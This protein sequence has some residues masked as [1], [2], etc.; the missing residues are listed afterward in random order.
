MTKSHITVLL[1]NILDVNSFASFLFRSMFLDKF[2]L[3]KV[4]PICCLRWILQFAVFG[5]APVADPLTKDNESQGLLDT[6]QRLVAVWSKREFVQ[7]ATME[8]HA[9]I[10]YH[11]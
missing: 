7:S 1:P 4:F 10:L 5:C 6:V 11:F 3:W 8:Q 9:C 2:L